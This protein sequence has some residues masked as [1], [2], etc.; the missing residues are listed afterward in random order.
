MPLFVPDCTPWIL[1]EKAD[2]NNAQAN[3][4]TAN[5]C[6]FSPIELLAQVVLLSLW[7]QCGTAG[8]GTLQLGLYDGQQNLLVASPAPG[9]SPIA[10]VTNSMISYVLASAMPLA[11]GRYYL[12]LWMSS[13]LD[14][15]YSAELTLAGGGPGLSAVNAAGLPALM[16]TI[17]PTAFHR[18]MALW[19]KI[20]GGF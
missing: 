5:T 14:Q 3:L 11:K 19:G 9:N 4:R 18:R 1:G 7:T 10:T 16:S 20:Q 15:T 8:N 2:L 12:G 13:S 17:S 6:Y